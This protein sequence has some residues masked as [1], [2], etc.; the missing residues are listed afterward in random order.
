MDGH[1]LKCLFDFKTHGMKQMSR[2]FKNMQVKVYLVYGVAAA[3]GL[4]LAWFVFAG[5]QAVQKN[6]TSLTQ[7]HIPALML[8]RELVA[9]LSEQERIHY[10][11]Y[12]TTNNQM[13]VSQY[14]P[15]QQRL[16]VQLDTLVNLAGDTDMHHKMAEKL[17]NISHQ[18][19]LLN[20]NLSNEKIDWDL[21]REQLSQL[22]QLR[23]QLLPQLELLIAEVNIDVDRGYK[24]TLDQVT[25]TSWSVTIF[26]GGLLLI[27]LLMGR[28]AANYIRLSLNN[29]RLAMFPQRNPN[30]VLSLSAQHDVLYQNPATEKLLRELGL[31]A[32]PLQ[33]FSIQLVS[34]LAETRQSRPPVRFFQHQIHNRFL[35]YAV[36]WLNDVEAFDIHVQDL[37]QQMQAE[38]RLA[39]LA[40]HHDL[41]GMQ[42]RLRFIEDVKSLVKSD[43]VFSVILIEYTQ[44]SRLQ[45]HY[46]IDGLTEIVKATSNALTYAI[47]KWEQHHQLRPQIYQITDASFAVIIT[48]ANDSHLVTE[49]CQSLQQSTGQS[50][51]TEIGELHV[52]LQLGVTEYPR[53][54]IKAED[55]LLH[56]KI[57]IDQG[58]NSVN[59][60]DHQT[61]TKHH[62]HLMLNERLVHAIDNQELELYF[63]PQMAITDR[64]LAGAETLIRWKL[65]GQFVSPAEFIPLAEQSGYILQLGDWILA[66]AVQKAAAMQLEVPV[67]IAVNI[68]ARQFMQPDFVKRVVHLLTTYQLKPELLELEITES[69]VMENEQAGLAVLTAL[70]AEGI[71]LAIDDFGTGY[72][73]L[74][75]L[76]SFPVDKLKIDQSF[77]RSMHQEPRDQAIVLSLCQLAHNF[78][79]KV[80]A[81]G[82]EKPEQLMLLT[83]YG[84]DAIQGYWFSRPLPETEFLKF[85]LAAG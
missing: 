7:Q 70:K 6:A 68:S 52:S 42:N 33:L 4:C 15:L 60:F 81:E 24:Q 80:I 18:S 79:M 84:C 5:M 21:A 76:K 74:S 48:E 77:I 28:Y 3:L 73:S 54:S 85:C 27:S 17:N 25:A 36:H 26:S 38:A 82:V 46:G 30:P 43:L 40:Y 61:G 32:D 51:Q 53:C 31:T 63:Q 20:V 10:E 23:R 59:F 1:E 39:Y 44:Y 55:I 64:S 71:C 37:T 12:A 78:G 14:V 16:K 11:Y 34:E 49:L 56:A 41:T 69:M 2:T 66:T 67:R 35:R 9:N 65:D 19:Q 47:S 57:A 45:S 13:Y 72:S 83:H 22:S 75:Y 8:A 29:E 50:L 62:R 58:L